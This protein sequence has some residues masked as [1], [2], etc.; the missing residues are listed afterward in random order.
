MKYL[1][2]ILIFFILTTI[3]SC[4]KESSI[5]F[6]VPSKYRFNSPNLENKD[7]Y[8]VDQVTKKAKIIT[9]SLGSFNRPNSE[10]SD[11]VNAIISKEFT[12]NS[13]RAIT[14]N[15]DNT[16]LLE[17][18][19]LDTLGSRDTIISTISTN[20]KYSFTGN[21]IKFDAYPD[22]FITLT[23]SFLELHFCQQFTL[24]SQKTQG[25]TSVKKYFK[26]NCTNAEPSAVINNIIMLNPSILYD[27]IS[28]E[29]VNYIY[30]TY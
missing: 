28:L 7:V 20:T 29:Y 13:L 6:V 1:N 5:S 27:T 17:F 25:G 12:S 14:F 21:Q 26:G 18:G 11:S 16:A 2:T 3:Y 10:I 23:N 8:L 22:F 15:S 9:D 24:R 30:S 4:I 19:K